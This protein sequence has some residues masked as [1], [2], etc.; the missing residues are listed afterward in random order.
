MTDCH[1]QLKP[2]H[3]REPSVNLGLGSMQGQIPHLVGE[4]L[5]KKAGV[6]PGTP[7]AAAYTYLDFEKPRA[8]TARWAA[9]RT[10]PRWSSA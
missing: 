4:S 8:A 1:A 5:L 9:L 10:W 2:I 3:F 7:L 6:R